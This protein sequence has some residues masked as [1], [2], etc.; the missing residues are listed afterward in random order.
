MQGIWTNT[1]TTPLERQSEFAGRVFL[2]DEELS[3]I[4]LQAAQNRDRPPPPD[5]TG[6]Y[7]SFWLDSGKWFRQ[8]S[9]IVDPPDGTLPAK[10]ARVQKR[11]DALA[12]VRRRPPTSW[13]DMNLYDRCITRGLPGAMIPGFYNH[14]H[15]LLHTPDYVV[16]AVEMIHDARI[17]P[18]DGRPRLPSHLGQWL[19]DAQG[20]WDGETEGNYALRNILRGARGEEKAAAQAPK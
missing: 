5:S 18:L 2:T 11:D 8:T 14:N 20:H 1:T 16:L 3:E 15:Q 12:A 7:N 6:A 17:I 9:L 13:E 4:D 19:G 10:T